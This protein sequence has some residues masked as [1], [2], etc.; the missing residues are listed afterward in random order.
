MRLNQLTILFLF[1][2]VHPVSSQSRFGLEVKAGRTT[3]FNS[4]EMMGGGYGLVW[5]TISSEQDLTANNQSIG[6]TYR[7]NERN[8]LKLHLGRHQNGRV[9]T[10][11][12]CDDSGFCQSFTNANAVYHY[13]QLAPS[14]AFRIL[15]KRIIIP[16]EAGINI[17]MRVKEAYILLVGINEFNFDYEFSTGLDYKL[18]PNFLIGLHGIYTSNINEYQDKMSVYGTYK[19][20]QLGFEFSINY[21]FG[22]TQGREN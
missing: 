12:L 14:Y 11:M 21:E 16:L 5:Y 10:A 4:G 6:M 18:E 1:I 7:L 20:K 17:N 15:N 22:E 9:I 13:I 2:I 8:L 3:T 19:P